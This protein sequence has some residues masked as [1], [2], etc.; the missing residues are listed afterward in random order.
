MFTQCSVPHQRLLGLLNCLLLL[1]EQVRDLPGSPL[2][3][4]PRLLRL[5]VLLPEVLLLVLLV[6]VLPQVCIPFLW[7][8][9]FFS[10]FFPPLGAVMLT[11]AS[12]FLMLT[13]AFTAVVMFCL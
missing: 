13:T 6:L 11:T 9:L 7:A 3:P 8:N 12:A 4:H 5:Q 2:V 1:V 10:Y